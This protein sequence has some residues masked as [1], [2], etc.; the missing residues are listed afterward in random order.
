MSNRELKK[1]IRWESLQFLKAATSYAVYTDGEKYYFGKDSLF[2]KL[3]DYKEFPDLKSLDAF[4]TNEFEDMDEEEE[5]D[6][7]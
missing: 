5:L 2:W 4:L 7:L 6:E 3:K 1:K